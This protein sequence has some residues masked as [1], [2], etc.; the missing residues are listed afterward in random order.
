MSAGACV[1]RRRLM[2]GAAALMAFGAAA[3]A[4]R[5][6]FGITI[7]VTAEGLFNPT[8]QVA[9]VVQ[10]DPALPAARAGIA[11][12][13]QVLVVDGRRIP[14]ATAGDLAPL[15]QGKR[16]GESVALVLGRPDGK[17]YAVQLTAVPPNRP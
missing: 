2:L 14:G 13:D 9:R 17:Q 3:Q 16:I 7:A 6:V 11:V 10:V 1:H 5:G 4:D 12:G 8:V 15:A